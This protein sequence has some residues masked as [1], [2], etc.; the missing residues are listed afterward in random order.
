VNGEGG[1]LA[2]FGGKGLGFGGLGADVAGEVERIADHDAN[3]GK[4][5]S[6]TGQGAQ[7]V[8]AVMMAL[9]SEDGLGREPQ[10]VGDSDA[11]AAIANVEGEIA[12]MRGDFQF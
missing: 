8:A 7:V 10:F 11:D 1:Q 12:G 3:Y 2:E 9:Q 6:E 4:T 5:P